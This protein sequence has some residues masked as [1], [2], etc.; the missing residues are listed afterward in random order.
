MRQ[1]TNALICHWTATPGQGCEGVR[2][3][4][5]S[6][7]LGQDGY[8]S[9]HRGIDFDGTIHQWIP[10]EEIAYAVG[11]S[12]VDPASGK[13]Y[14][15]LAEQLFGAYAPRTLPATTSPN[16]VTLS[17]EWMTLDEK[18]TFTTEQYAAAVELYAFWAYTYALDPLTEILTH[19]DVVGWKDCHKFFV[20]NPDKFDT[21]KHDVKDAISNL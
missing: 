10:D 19:K 6:R 8:G 18:G 17:C 14:T 20:D 16:W 12:Q 7:K 4:Y 9:A 5:E 2:N 3:F 1:G 21:F 13:I 11:S 15:D